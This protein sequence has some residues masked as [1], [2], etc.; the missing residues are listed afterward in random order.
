MNMKDIIF[1]TYDSEH[2]GNEDLYS[3][4]RLTEPFLYAVSFPQD[5]TLL[6]SFYKNQ[7]DF[8]GNTAFA[9]NY[10]HIDCERQYDSELLIEAVEYVD[11]LSVFQVAGNLVMDYIASQLKGNDHISSPALGRYV[12]EKYND[13]IRD[14]IRIYSETDDGKELIESIDRLNS[15]KK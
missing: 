6:I 13:Y 12:R 1:F 14:C 9:K 5:C 7:E 15:E 4:H 8:E 10:V 11:N 2:E 3:V